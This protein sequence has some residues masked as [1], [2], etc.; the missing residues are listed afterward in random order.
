MAA[1]LIARRIGRPPIGRRRVLLILLALVVVTVAIPLVTSA[2]TTNLMGLFVPLIILAIAIDLLWGENH[3]VSFGHGAFFT[4]GGY[5][6]G[7]VLLGR[8]GDVVNQTT[9]FL[10]AAGEP[11]MSAQVLTA[12]NG[13]QLA[14]IP[15]L[16]LLLAPLVCGIA[17]TLI[18]F[19]AFR[20]GSPE[21]YVPL[22]TLGIGVIA[23]LALNDVQALGG[24]NGL[25]GVPSYTANT[26]FGV[27]G[28]YFFG[29][30]MVV[31]VYAGYWAFRRSRHGTA[32]RAT[33]DDP[34]RM[35]ALGHHVHRTRALGFGASAALA[36]LS[37]AVYVGASGY[38]GPAN[39]GVTFSTQA[40]IWVAVGGVGTLLGPLVGVMFVKW[41]EHILSSVLG[42]ADSWQL[43]LGLTLVLVVIVAPRGI[44][45]L[46]GQVRAALRGRG[47][48][49]PVSTEPASP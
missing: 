30:A 27:N 44:T 10:G 6:G 12:L 43:F 23:A 22:V 40:L 33:G 25:G 21:V 8:T 46:P 5:L 17:G 11:S 47:R 1:T 36:G 3:I 15:F 39:A 2:Y 49:S 4:V 32:W 16:G 26:S 35:E 29:V 24:S 13:V 7:L 20:I 45:G 34:V 18:G 37:G 38:V 31:V 28:P 48:G 9:D 42:L 14:G 19:L 41:G